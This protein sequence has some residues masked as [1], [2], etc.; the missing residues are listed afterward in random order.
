MFLMAKSIAFTHPFPTT[1][2]TTAAAVSSDN[3][4][5]QNMSSK[6]MTAPCVYVGYEDG[7]TDEEGGGGEGGRQRRQRD[8]ESTTLGISGIGTYTPSLIVK[9][10]VPELPKYRK[11]IDKAS[12]GAAWKASNYLK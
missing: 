3:T 1:A 11:I 5:V 6:N 10:A 9:V 8:M 12:K 4:G 2:A 7:T